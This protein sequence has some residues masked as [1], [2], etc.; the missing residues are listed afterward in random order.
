MV[1]TLILPGLNGS[2]ETHWQRIWA[3]DCPGAEVVEQANW[4]C[5]NLE[6]W[7]ATL[8]RR[9]AE[10]EET[11]CLVAHSL[12]CWLAASIA[13]SPHAAKIQSALLVAPCDLDVVEKLH[14]CAVQ[15][16]PRTDRKLPF[17][18]LVIGSDND[19]YM[20][21]GRLIDQAETWGSEVRLLG[22]VGHIN[23]DSGFGRW[24]NGYQLFNDFNRKQTFHSLTGGSRPSA[25]RV[26]L[27]DAV[28]KSGLSAIP[29]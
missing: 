8:E 19:P 7:K 27:L 9:L 28:I 15:T 18:S 17:P 25:A 3:K 1:R 20:T 13:T 11:V 6:T 26:D 10:A 12:G 5:P 29:H 2:G 22:S 24:S 23:V 4:E 21:P 14:P 16:A